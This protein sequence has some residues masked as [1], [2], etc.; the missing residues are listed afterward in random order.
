MKR[1]RLLFLFFFALG[2]VAL[3]LILRERKGTIAESIKDFAV[4]DTASIDKI[5]LAS[6]SGKSV[7]L[8]KLKSGV[9]QVN[10]KYNVRRD[11]I[12][13]LLYT[14]KMVDVRE[15]VG[16]R[17]KENV[18]KRLASNSTKIEIFQ[19]NKL[20]KSYYVGGETS[21][22]TGTYMLMINLET[23]TNSSEPFVTYI[24][25]FDGYLTT[26]YFTEEAEWRDRMVYNYIPPKIKS[27]LLDYN[28]TQESS[29]EID[30]ISTSDF[31]L[32]NNTHQAIFDFEIDAIKEYLSNF[33]NIHYEALIDQMS[34]SKRDSIIKNELF[35]TIEIIDVSG[36]KNKVKIYKKEAPEDKLE[37]TG[38]PMK[39]DPDRLYALINNDEDF[40]LIQYY[41]FGKLLQ[42]INFFMKRQ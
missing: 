32:K 10:N 30:V 41:N 26:R 35:A 18:V 5:F 4:Q 13:L 20:V 2:I 21:D 22:Q 7:T 14:I 38:E 34:K 36:Q 12:E 27:V 37:V 23:G 17:A 42:P 15:P 1:V 25:G 9:W 16:K 31:V 28:E 6:K 11:A 33:Q 3:W 29:F 24:P 40:V 39:Y 8:I 19:S